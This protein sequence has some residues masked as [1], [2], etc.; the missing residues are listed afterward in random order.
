MTKIKTG[1][2]RATKGKLFKKELG[3]ISRMRIPTFD[4]I[5]KAIHNSDIK[6]DGRN[7]WIDGDELTL[8][9]LWKK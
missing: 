6:Y 7:E 3:D 1:I 8:E 4:E 9:K 5:N 2:K